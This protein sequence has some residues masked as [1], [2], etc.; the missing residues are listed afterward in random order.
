MYWNVTIP[1]SYGEVGVFL[2]EKQVVEYCLVIIFAAQHLAGV[3]PT[4]VTRPRVLDATIKP[5]HGYQLQVNNE[6]YVIERSARERNYAKGSS[7]GD[8]AGREQ[9]VARKVG[10]VLMQE[11]CSAESFTEI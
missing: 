5:G 11:T 1:T 6:I 4:Q 10:N 3:T 8:N 9:I 2:I 7:W